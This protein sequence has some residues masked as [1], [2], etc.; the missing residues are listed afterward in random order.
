MDYTEQI[1][2]ACEDALERFPDMPDQ[3][4][5][6]IVDFILTGVIRDEKDIYDATDV[7]CI[8]KKIYDATARLT[9]GPRDW[10]LFVRSLVS[11]YPSLDVYSPEWPRHLQRYREYVEEYEQLKNTEDA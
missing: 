3:L 7:T 1:V 5:Q 9:C 2:A 10:N 8:D 6:G 11:M 4:K